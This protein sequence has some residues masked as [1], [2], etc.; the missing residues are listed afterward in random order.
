MQLRG[1]TAALLRTLWTD[2]SP[3]RGESLS[4]PQSFERTFAAMSEPLPPTPGNRSVAALLELL[5]FPG[6]GLF[7]LGN[8]SWGV[9]YIGAHLAAA[10]AIGAGALRGTP[11]LVW[12]GLLG[13]V[14]QRLIAAGHCFFVEGEKPP[15]KRFLIVGLVGVASYFVPTTL[16]RENVVEAFRIPSGSMEPNLKDGDHI[17]VDKMSTPRP[18]DVVIFRDEQGLAFAKRLVAIGPGTISIREGRVSVNSVPLA[19]ARKSA[20]CPLDEACTVYEEVNAGEHYSILMNDPSYTQGEV[21]EALLDVDEVYLL[22]DNRDS[23]ADSRS[24]GPSHLSDV[25]GVV[26]MVWWRAGE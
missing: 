19:Q 11:V 26:T 10:L 13:I 2:A 5:T 18:G 6:A 24:L 4:R 14:L 7:C 20:P 25:E 15:R 16:I 8:R 17:F 1:L 22:G 23:S 9:A 12:W 21:F 3:V